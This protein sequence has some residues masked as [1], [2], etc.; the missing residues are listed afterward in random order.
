M[1]QMVS[2][3]IMMDLISGVMKFTFFVMVSQSSTNSKP[4]FFLAQSGRGF[5][6]KYFLGRIA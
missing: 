5:G 6:L 2:T 3:I 4:D 1:K